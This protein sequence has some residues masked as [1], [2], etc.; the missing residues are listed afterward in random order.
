MVLALAGCSLL[1]PKPTATP[2]PASPTP[3][4]TLT[5]PLAPTATPTITPTM[6]PDPARPWGRYEG[7]SLPSVTQI[8]YPAVRLEVSR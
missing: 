6:T 7:P 3:S 4:A 5:L 8:P 1:L 2:I